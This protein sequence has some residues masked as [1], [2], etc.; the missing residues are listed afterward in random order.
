MVDFG[1]F[2][3]VPSQNT[4]RVR[5]K[6]PVTFLAYKFCFIIQNFLICHILSYVEFSYFFQGITITSKLAGTTM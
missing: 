5:V 1:G 3:K 4:Q 2:R 6:Q